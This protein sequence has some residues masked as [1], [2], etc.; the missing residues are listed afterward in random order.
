V[1]WKAKYGSNRNYLHSFVKLNTRKDN[2]LVV[3]GVDIL[4]E[5]PLLD[6]KPYIPK[7]D[8]IPF[9]SEGWTKNK[10]WREKPKGRE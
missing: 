9:A 3:Q 4:D 5:T 1:E 8:S 10:R 6:I 7:Y 2:V